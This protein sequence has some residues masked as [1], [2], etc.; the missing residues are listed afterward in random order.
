MTPAL[1]HAQLGRKLALPRFWPLRTLACRV[2]AGVRRVSEDL[3]SDLSD[4]SGSVVRQQAVCWQ[5]FS[6]SRHMPQLKVDLDV[7]TSK[8]AKN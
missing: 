8:S 6:A 5:Q 2:L 7:G 1:G 3:G 4:Q